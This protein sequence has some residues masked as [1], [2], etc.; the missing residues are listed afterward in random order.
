MEIKAET[1]KF[2]HMKRHNKFSPLSIT[3]EYLIYKN[4]NN[5]QIMNNQ[6]INYSILRRKKERES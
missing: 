5:Y 4:K 2:N 6:K 1:Q 3:K